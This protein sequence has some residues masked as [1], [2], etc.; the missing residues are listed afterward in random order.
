MG[1][2]MGSGPATQLASLNSDV[3]GLIL[4]SPFTSLKDAV[5]SLLGK[6]P[7]LLVR[8]RFINR[9]AIQLVKSPVLIIHGESDSLIPVTHAHEL[10]ARC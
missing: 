10:Y 3:A 8:D 1:R 2:S 6:F 7:S 4:L 5:R 9:Q